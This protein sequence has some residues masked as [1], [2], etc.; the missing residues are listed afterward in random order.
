MWNALSV[1]VRST[2]KVSEFQ[3]IVW[4]IEGWN[5]P[6]SLSTVL[7]AFRNSSSTAG[8]HVSSVTSILGSMCIG[9]A[10]PKISIAAPY[11]EHWKGGYLGCH[12]WCS[13]WSKN[14]QVSNT[15]VHQRLAAILVLRWTKPGRM[16]SRCA[17][18]MVKCQKSRCWWQMR[19]QD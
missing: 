8:T 11:T 14:A 4:W 7:T 3:L 5:L 6:P 16:E 19:S 17:A 9:R 10:P 12:E 1:Q 18:L 2:Q 13:S 15:T